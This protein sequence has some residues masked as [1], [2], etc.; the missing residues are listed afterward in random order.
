MIKYSVVQQRFAYL[1]PGM[2]G[3]EEY[4]HFPSF[5]ASIYG[6]VADRPD[7]AGG[8]RWLVRRP[9][10]PGRPAGS[11][12]AGRPPEHWCPHLLSIPEH[13]VT[14]GSHISIL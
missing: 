8:D 12:S 3:D 6:G 11:Q 10:V 7:A 9:R 1:V 2:W 13:V 14:A 5:H 4:R